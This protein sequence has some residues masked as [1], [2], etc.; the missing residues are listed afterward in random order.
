MGLIALYCFSDFCLLLVL[1]CFFVWVFGCL[2]G[3]RCGFGLLFV[4]I[5][6]CLLFFGVDLFV[7]WFDCCG[8]CW[9]FCFML[10]GWYLFNSVVVACILYLLVYLCWYYVWFILF[11]SSFLLLVWCVA[12][13]CCFYCLLLIALIVKYTKD[14]VF[15]FDVMFN[16]LLLVAVSYLL[17]L[18]AFV[19]VVVVYLVFVFLGL[20]CCWCF[21]VYAIFF[22]CFYLRLCWVVELGLVGLDICLFI[23]G[24]LLL[25]CCL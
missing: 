21:V 9:L 11:D 8:V 3:L 15:G 12:V 10:V 16:C 22:C 5:Y 4:C 23:Y 6:V 17:L 1:L 18:L 7:W 14:V 20:L 13:C 25:L 24:L 19:W 2:L